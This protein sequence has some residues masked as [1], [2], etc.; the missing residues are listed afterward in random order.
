MAILDEVGVP[1]DIRGR[2][3]DVL[4]TVRPQVISQA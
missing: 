2:V 3:V 1:D 4:T